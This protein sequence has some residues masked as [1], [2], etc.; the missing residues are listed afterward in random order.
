MRVIDPCF[1][2][3]ARAVFTKAGLDKEEQHPAEESDEDNVKH[4]GGEIPLTSVDLVI[5][6]SAHEE[7]GCDDVIDMEEAGAEYLLG[8][9]L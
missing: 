3:V 9:V 4:E 2:G 5:A 8:A 7:V 6:L 1:E